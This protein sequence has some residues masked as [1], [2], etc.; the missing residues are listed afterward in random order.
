M[1][2]FVLYGMIKMKVIFLEYFPSIVL[3]SMIVKVK[4]C[5]RLMPKIS[6]NK[7]SVLKKST[8]KIRHFSIISKKLSVMKSGSS[9][10][11]N[12]VQE[13]SQKYKLVYKIGVF[14]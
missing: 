14:F 3:S 2:W 11:Y 5:F 10:R 4:V 7:I 8:K 13:I 6:R 12:V 9:S 1:C